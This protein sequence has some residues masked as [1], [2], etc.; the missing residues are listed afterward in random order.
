MATCVALAAVLGS[1]CSSDEGVESGSDAPT[2]ATPSST[3]TGPTTTTTTTAEPTPVAPAPPSFESAVQATR[4]GELVVHADVAEDIVGVFRALYEARFPI[5]QMRLVDDF[6]GDDDRS[7]EANNTSAFN[8]RKATGSSRWS[9]H[10]YGRAVD[11]NPVQNPYVTRSG[12]MLPPSGGPFV[13]RGSCRHGADRV[14]RA[15]R[16]RLRRDRLGVGRPLVE[17]EGLSA[18]LGEQS[19][20]RECN[21]VPSGLEGTPDAQD[22]E[23][24]SSGVLDGTDDG[25]VGRREMRVGTAESSV[26]KAITPPPIHSQTARG[27]MTTPTVTVPFASCGAVTSVR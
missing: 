24:A 2:T 26:P 21:G 9:E 7:M 27:W 22:M 5:D 23:S 20:S 13:D 6:G 3:T 8:C 15:G 1:A 12:A 19:L 14:R 10:A 4:T 25:S 11:L 18:L 17:R 16:A